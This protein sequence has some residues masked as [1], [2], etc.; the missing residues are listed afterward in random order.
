MIVVYSHFTYLKINPTNDKN[1]PENANF[2]Q[3]IARA[4]EAEECGAITSNLERM[5]KRRVVTAY[6]MLPND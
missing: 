5:K 2:P 6:G 3:Y 1:Y 4:I